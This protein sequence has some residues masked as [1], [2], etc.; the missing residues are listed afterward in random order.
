MY[1]GKQILKKTLAAGLVFSMM[2]AGLQP[3][4]S[5]AKVRV[6]YKSSSLYVGKSIQLKIKGTKKKVI[7]KSSNKKIANVSKKGKVT[8][9]KCGTVTITAKLSGSSQTLKSR[10]KVG[11]YITGIKLDSA[12]VVVLDH[13]STS[14]IRAS[15]TG[16]NPLYKDMTFASSKK[17]V[18]TVTANGQIKG[19]AEGVADILVT[20][21]AKNK[22]G[23]KCQKKVI[24]VVNAA[25]GSDSTAKPSPTASAGTTATPG[26]TS[27]P[28][29]STAPSAA[30]TQSARIISYNGAAPQ[31]QDSLEQVIKNI[32]APDTS[33]M[34][35]A[36]IVM[37]ENGTT[38]TLYFLN[39]NYTGTMSLEVFGN[40]FSSSRSVSDSLHTIA[41]VKGLTYIYRNEKDEPVMS[42]NDK[43][44]NCTVTNLLTEEQIKFQVYEADTVYN[45]PYGLIVAGGDT[46]SKITLK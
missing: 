15:V 9:K 8:G 32:P 17:E 11:N 4:V 27:T 38:S 7:W 45:S 21:H 35:P 30:P 1:K 44:G 16:K 2:A 3:A 34:V 33:V 28:V 46:T 31:T 41:A 29:A 39:K 37:E 24:V 42:I 14:Q 36:T 25:S 23:K 5:Q 43:K 18:A 19:I 12:D 6:N 13:G 10:I 40:S 22:S 20:S 26:G